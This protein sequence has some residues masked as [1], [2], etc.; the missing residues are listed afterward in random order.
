MIFIVWYPSYKEINI[1]WSLLEKKQVHAILS[2]LLTLHALHLTIS[3]YKPKNQL[4]KKKRNLQ[5]WAQATSS[6]W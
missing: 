5:L 6:I 2:I 1:Y 4:K 3:G